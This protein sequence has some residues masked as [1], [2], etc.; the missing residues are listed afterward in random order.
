MKLKCK[1]DILSGEM[2]KPQYTFRF[3]MFE[4]QF[5]Y[6]YQPFVKDNRL[7]F[8]KSEFIFHIVAEKRQY[9][10]LRIT[11]HTNHDSLA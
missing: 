2:P 5:R 10:H 1:G 11:G 9:L 8:V 6:S 4:L 7:I 3:F